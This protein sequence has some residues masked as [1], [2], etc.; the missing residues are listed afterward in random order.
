M[1]HGRVVSGREGGREAG[2]ILA[3]CTNI[4]DKVYVSRASYINTY[5]SG[6]EGAREG[7][8]WHGRK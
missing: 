4:F 8:S 6:K 1:F 5:I 2:Q 3:I 7:K